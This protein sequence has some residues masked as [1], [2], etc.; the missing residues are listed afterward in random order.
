MALQP[1]NIIQ[2]Y[3]K[4]FAVVFFLLLMKPLLRHNILGFFGNKLPF[5]CT[6]TI[7]CTMGTQ[8]LSKFLR[9]SNT[10]RYNSTSYSSNFFQ[11]LLVSTSEKDCNIVLSCI[12]TFKVLIS[13]NNLSCFY[14]IYYFKMQV[15]LNV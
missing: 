7:P 15:V 1:L 2:V 10:N 12:W 6:A 8:S 14:F 11:V 9:P 4:V 3:W 5:H 13:Q